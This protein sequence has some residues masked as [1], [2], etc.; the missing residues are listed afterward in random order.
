M[1]SAF[2][3]ILERIS[4]AQAPEET[5]INDIVDYGG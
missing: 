4:S 5:I 1:V 2:A 3:F